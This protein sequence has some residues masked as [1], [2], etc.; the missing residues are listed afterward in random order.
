MPH[1]QS[2]T[3]YHL[4][5]ELRKLFRLSKLENIHVLVSLWT[6]VCQAPLSLRA[7][8]LYKIP[9]L[10]TYLNFLLT[11]LLTYLF[12]YLLIYFDYWLRFIN[13]YK[14]QGSLCLR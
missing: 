2:E 7:Y 6:Y 3:Y 14:L 12:T 11:Y 8:W 13:A 1:L 4:I 5:C 10:L 9:C